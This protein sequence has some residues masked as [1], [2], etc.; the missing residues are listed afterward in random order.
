MFIARAFRFAQ[1]FTAAT[2]KP[3]DCSDLKKGAAQ[4][5]Q[6]IERLEAEFA[7]A[8]VNFVFMILF[9]LYFLIF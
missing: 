5:Q 6:R 1:F 8:E 7:E 4:Y 9:L 3:I 2:S